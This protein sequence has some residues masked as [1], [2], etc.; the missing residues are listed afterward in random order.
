[1]PNALALWQV[2]YIWVGDGIFS[3]KG[4]AAPCR[5]TGAIG[6][7]LQ[8]IKMMVTLTVGESGNTSFTGMQKGC[9]IDS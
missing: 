1:M 6:T 9:G 3:E 7:V 5:F 4:I 8:E 2:S